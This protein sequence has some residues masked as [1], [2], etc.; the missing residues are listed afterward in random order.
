[1][2]LKITRALITAAL[3]GHLANVSYETHDIFRLRMPKE[4]PGVPSD[5]LDPKNTWDDKEDY[6]LKANLLAKKFIDNFEKFK[7]GASKAVLAARPVT[8]E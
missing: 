4:C 6:D 3:E 2:S 8:K 1:M 7:D 5:V